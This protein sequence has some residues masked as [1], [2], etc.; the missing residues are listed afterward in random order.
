ML[1]ALLAETCTLL[2]FRAVIE[3]EGAATIYSDLYDDG[4]DADITAND[5]V[6]ARYFARFDDDG[7]YTIKCQVTSDEDTEVNGGFIVSRDLMYVKEFAA[8]R[9][10]RGYPLAPTAATPICCGSDA[11]LRRDQMDFNPTGV[12][13]RQGTVG[14]IQ[15][16]RWTRATYLRCQIEVQTNFFP[17][18]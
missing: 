4:S 1:L 11:T 6:Y 16:M 8:L 7:R 9:R 14:S 15:V 18:V 3:K 13:N 2:Y 10:E 5:G 17:Q 12:F